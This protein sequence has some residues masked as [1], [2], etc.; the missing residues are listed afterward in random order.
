[1]EG[2]IYP[3]ANNIVDICFEF[4]E[5]LPKAGKP[6]VD[7]EWTVLSCIIQSNDITKQMEVVALGTGK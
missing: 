4:F 5:K 3:D 6:I 2:R 7:N 1:M